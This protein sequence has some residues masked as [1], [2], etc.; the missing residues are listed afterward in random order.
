MLK[1][2]KQ[3][4]W[5][6]QKISKIKVPVNNKKDIYTP[7][8]WNLERQLKKTISLTEQKNIEETRKLA[9]L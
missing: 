3:Q 7:N 2:N 8:W 5:H 6:T 4:C 9:R 1:K